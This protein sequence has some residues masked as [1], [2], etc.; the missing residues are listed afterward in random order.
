MTPWHQ[1]PWSQK[2]SPFLQT[3][4]LH[5]YIWHINLKYIMYR[6]FWRYYIISSQHLIW[7]AGKF[8]SNAGQFTQHLY[9]ISPIDPLLK[10]LHMPVQLTSKNTT[11]FIVLITIYLPLNSVT[12]TIL[13][14][15]F[16]N[17]YDL[18]PLSENILCKPI[19]HKI[20]LQIHPQ[21]NSCQQATYNNSPSLL[22][23]WFSHSS[24]AVCGYRSSSSTHFL[25]LGLYTYSPEEDDKSYVPKCETT[26]ST[27]SHSPNLFQCSWCSV[28]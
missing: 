6:Y 18:I 25:C 9:L 10:Q 17:A 19:S 2:I 22:Y 23:V 15:L 26:H 13:K 28:F 8:P 20:S 27:L 4:H 24:W 14:A 21:K 16:S 12:I 1:L 5:R 11:F 3:K 7:Q